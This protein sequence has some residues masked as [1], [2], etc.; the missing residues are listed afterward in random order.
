MPVLARGRAGRLISVQADNLQVW[1]NSM[2]RYQ[3]VNIKD[4][5]IAQMAEQKMF[6]K[7]YVGG[8]S[9]PSGYKNLGVAQFGRVLHPENS[10][11]L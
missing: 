5:G 4:S 11:R 9:P 10:R 8:S 3:M 1:F 6:N 7:H 2:H